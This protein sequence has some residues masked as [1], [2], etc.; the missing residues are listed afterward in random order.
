MTGLTEIQL[1][2]WAKQGSIVQSAE[3]FQTIKNCL[4]QPSSGYAY[5]D[6]ENFLQG[7]FANSTNIYADS[8][9]DIVQALNSTFYRDL[10]GLSEQ[11]KRAYNEHFGSADYSYKDFK[12]DVFKQLSSCFGTRVEFRNKAI[13]VPG[14]DNNRRDADVLPAA[15]YRKYYEFRTSTHQRYA[16]GII[17]WTND[18]TEIV[19]YPR[20]HLQNSTTKNTATLNQF[21][22]NCR[23]F[24]NYRNA[25]IRDGYIAKGR[26]PSYFLEGALYNVP[27]GLFSYSHR[28]TVWNSLKWWQSCDRSHLVCVNEMY[29]LLHPT[30]PVT[31]REEHFNEWVAAAIKY[32]LDQ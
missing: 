2:T 15:Q 11:E 9:V 23:V 32:W 28:E 6:T 18:G 10:S 1:Q 26:A 7:S 16:Q 17:F 25:M 27:D 8:D 22:P 30:S 20:Q 13:F 14:N 3:T 19:N 12:T 24:K 21:K 5:K 31:W 4:D 29:K